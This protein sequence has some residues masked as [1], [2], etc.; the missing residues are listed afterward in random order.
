MS[1]L[2]F[3]LEELT[4]QLHE[5]GIPA[6]RAKQMMEWVYKKR[7]SSWGEMKNLPLALREELAETYPLIFPEVVTISGSHDTTQKFLL[8]FSDGEMIETVGGLS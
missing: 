8:R 4:A 7:I 3:T 6:Y 1:L 2:N 5:K